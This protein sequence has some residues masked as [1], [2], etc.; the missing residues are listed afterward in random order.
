VLAVTDCL[1]IWTIY[2]RPSDYPD[3]WVLRG[4]EILQRRTQPHEVCF[5]AATL[6]EIRAKV[7][8]GNL[9][10][11]REPEDHPV[12]HETWI[13]T[14]GIDDFADLITTA[15]IGPSRASAPQ[16]APGHLGYQARRC[17]NPEITRR[18]RLSSRS[19]E[20][21]PDTDAD[22][23]PNRPESTSTAGATPDLEAKPVMNTGRA[24]EGEASARA[25][26][27]SETRLAVVDRRIIEA[28][29][30]LTAAVEAAVDLNRFRDTL[31]ST[32]RVIETSRACIEESLQTIAEI[33]RMQN[34]ERQWRISPVIEHSPTAWP[35]E[36][37]GGYT[38]VS[39]P[40][41]PSI[42]APAQSPD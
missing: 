17:R 22:G 38:A 39:N 9:R 10:I 36:D 16:P 27:D 29:A 35:E 20:W 12:I 26:P 7:P 11:D 6:E 21:L 18:I 1:T 8:P 33:G 14:F 3:S 24:P 34:W 13:P 15:T 41:Q 30:C 2:Y 40:G 28:E 23:G 19:A 25:T 32:K 5:V 4:H 37:P 42:P 31:R